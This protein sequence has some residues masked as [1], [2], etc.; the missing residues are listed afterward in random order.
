MTRPGIREISPGTVVEFFESK[1]I[2][3]GVVLAVKDGRL[4]VLTER[5]R[6]INLTRSRAIHHGETLLNLKLTRDELAKKLAEISARRKQLQ[7][8]IDLEEIWSLFEGEGGEFDPIEIAEFLFNKPV[9]DDQSAAIRRLLLEDRLY[10]QEKDARYSPRSSDSVEQRR[11]E[12]Q[13]EADRETRLSESAQWLEAVWGRK[14]VQPPP[15]R[16]EVVS[17]LKDYSVF[18]QEAKEATFVKEALKRAGI[19]PQPLSAFRLL[20]RIGVWNENENLLLHEH[21]ICRT[22]LP[23]VIERAEQ[24]SHSTVLE[25]AASG[26]E[27]L[28][29]LPT[30]TVDSEFTR[31]YDDALSIR[32]LEGGIFEVGVHIAD[33]AEFIPKGDLLDRVAEQR[34]SSI[35]L[36][37]ERISMFP[38]SLSEGALSLKAGVDRMALSFLIKMDRDANLLESRIV[39]SIVRIQRQL[40]YETV[41]SLIPGDASISI[42]FELA[43]KRRQRRLEQGA[44]ILPLAEIHVYVNNAG[45]I[46]ISRYEK[47]TPGQ[48]MVSEWM[49][50]AN[51]AA[52]DYLSE[53]G[54]PAVFRGQAECRPETE[55]VPSEHELFR[56]YRQRRLFS[57]AE[58]SSEPKVHCSLAIP[59]YT[60]VTSPIRR[61]SDL[62]VQRQL[63]QAI[64]GTADLYSREELDQFILRIGAAQARIFTIQRKW[65]KFW[66]LKY[67]EQE[68]I[69]MMHA[70]VL[71]KNPRFAHLLIPDFLLEVNAP[72]PENSEFKQGELVRINIEK[73]APRDDVLKIQIIESPHRS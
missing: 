41:D 71:D 5:N 11:T 54:V 55:C 30:F 62:L 64:A 26:R 20:V 42:L 37:D 21:G 68:D 19:V 8:D 18:G 36:P 27:D 23:E 48:I 15:F 28:T 9:P 16:N 6:E 34:V 59:R 14:S 72:V 60:T 67:I 39:P 33:V 43:M 49:I 46:Q 7:Q 35:Y 69:E 31:D 29:E 63:K 70:L 38:P 2:L 61:Y 51:A 1:E 47:E 58:L 53:K 17:D 44:I 40:T 50:E 10:F 12:I 13:K 3:C 45:M 57:R 25:T 66:I 24:I 22:F 65:T 32:E 52:A 56:V 73:V 4:H